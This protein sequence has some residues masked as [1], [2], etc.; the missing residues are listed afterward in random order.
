VENTG[1]SDL[2]YLSA[3]ARANCFAWIGKRSWRIIIGSSKG[4]PNML[5]KNGH[6]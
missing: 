2:L 5:E 3:K 6:E 1:C 4:L